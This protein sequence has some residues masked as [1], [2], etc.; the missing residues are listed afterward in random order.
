MTFRGSSRVLVPPA[1]DLSHLARRGV[2]VG[3]EPPQKQPWSHREP[4]ED[5]QIDFKI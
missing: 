1:R 4:L 5:V 3:P 2:L